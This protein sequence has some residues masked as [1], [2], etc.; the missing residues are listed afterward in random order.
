RGAG[1]KP[2]CR[3]TPAAVR[4]Q[5]DSTPGNPAEFGRRRNHPCNSPV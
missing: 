1:Q 5:F 3:G 2:H 4:G